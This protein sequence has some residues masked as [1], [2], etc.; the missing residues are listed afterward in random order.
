MELK[1]FVY[2]LVRFVPDVV[3]GER[4]N[5]GVLVVSDEDRDSAARFLSSFGQRV[6]ILDPGCDPGGLGRVLETLRARFCSVQRSSLY[7]LADER[8]VSKTGLQNLTD[9][10]T[11]ELQ[12]SKPRMY[13]SATLESAVDELFSDLVMPPGHASQ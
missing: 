11:N 3:R 1:T 13:R 9:I 5:L 4:I 7:D 12:L 10:L 8:I 2:S 6:T